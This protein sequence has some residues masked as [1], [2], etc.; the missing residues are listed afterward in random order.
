MSQGTKQTQVINRHSPSRDR[1]GKD[2]S[3]QEKLTK[4]GALSATHQI[5]EEETN[6]DIERRRSSTHNL[7]TTEGQTSRDTK[8]I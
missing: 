1:R 5:L 3:R 6:K 8:R 2:K 7:G 4:Q